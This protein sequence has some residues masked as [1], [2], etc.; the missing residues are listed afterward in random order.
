[1]HGVFLP[2]S[3]GQKLSTSE[4]QTT[5]DKTVDL[6]QL[7]NDVI[8]FKKFVHGEILSIK[9]TISSRLLSDGCGTPS[10]PS[11]RPPLD[12][13]KW[14]IKSLE[15]R[16]LS[17]EK[18]LDQKQNT[19]EKLMEN[20]KV[21]VA[22][23]EKDEFE[24]PMRISN[25]NNSITE[26]HNK[27]MK[28]KS[29]GKISKKNDSS[30]KINYTN[31][32]Q[33]NLGN[34]RQKH[35]EK[36][37]PREKSANA[38]PSCIIEDWPES[39]TLT[40]ANYN[41]KKR[42]FLIGDSIMNGIQEKGLSSRHNTRSRRCPGDTTKDLV[43]HIKPIARKRPDL[44]LIHFGTND[45]THSVDTDEYMQKVIDYLHKESPNTNIAVSL[46]TR[47]F[48]Q[49]GHDKKI[50][51]CNNVLKGICARNNLQYIDNSNIDESCLGIRKLHL[52]RKGTSYLANNLKHFIHDI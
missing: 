36:G 29:N 13:E 9:A 32:K 8:E 27:T 47:R 21:M 11:P 10:S 5:A 4:T 42:I 44:V 46:C 34:S 19:I 39:N 38:Q 25:S 22:S 28:N 1:M 50:A 52:N 24:T 49:P 23:A 15:D 48:D 6:H 26:D 30:R 17:L 33:T 35:A 18:Q 12:Y 43:D 37:K 3:D 7:A 41:S 31:Q 20:Q 14:F 16:I 2:P 51:A 40:R 45:I